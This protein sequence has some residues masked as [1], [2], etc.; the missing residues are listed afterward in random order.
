[1]EERTE[2]ESDSRR[3]EKRR[4]CWCCQDEQRACTI[5]QALAEKLQHTGA[6]EKERVASVPQREQLARTPNR[7][8]QKEKSRLSKVPDHE[9]ESRTLAR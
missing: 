1:M 9:G 7:P 3:A 4:T 6:A 8:C 2:R 5:A